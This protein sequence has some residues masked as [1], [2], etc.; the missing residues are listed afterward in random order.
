MALVASV[1]ER[2]KAESN[3]NTF[4]VRPPMRQRWV[5]YFARRC[6]LHGGTP[7]NTPACRFPVPAVKEIMRAVLADKLAEAKYSPDLTKDVADTI[8]AKVK[9]GWGA[10][11][12]GSP[13]ELLSPPLAPACA[14]LGLARYKFVVHVV[15]G[16]QRGEGVRIGTRCLWDATT[17]AM[18]TETFRNVRAGRGGARM[19]PHPHTPGC[20]RPLLQEAIFAVATTYGVYLY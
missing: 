18:A 19:L 14:D 4:A 10:C 7:N 5:G 12:R 1:V 20:V 11:G 17:D 15:V 16:E 8:R 13:R 3:E 9:G 6:D 2:K